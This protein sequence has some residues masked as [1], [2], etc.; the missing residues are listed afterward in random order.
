MTNDKE[1]QAHFKSLD[2]ISQ[3]K[4]ELLEGIRGDAKSMSALWKE[5]FSPQQKGRKKG[6]SLQSVMS[7]G[8]GVLDGALFAWKLYR[9]FKR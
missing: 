9:K 5:M 1:K 6:V 2:D 7:T 8:V 3:R 4:A